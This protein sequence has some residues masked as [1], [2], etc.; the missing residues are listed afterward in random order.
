MRRFFMETGCTSN[1]FNNR[2]K[3]VLELKMFK[4]SPNNATV[5]VN[6]I[7]NYVCAYIFT[8]RINDPK[9]ATFYI[10]TEPV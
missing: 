1:R 10:L 8:T 3:A 9:N 5:T 2:S 4:L 7:Y 6:G